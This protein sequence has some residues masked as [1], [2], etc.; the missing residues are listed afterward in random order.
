MD[1]LEKKK[2]PCPSNKK[3]K[4]PPHLQ[5]TYLNRKI[6]RNIYI[7]IVIFAWPA[8]LIR[9]DLQQRTVTAMTTILLNNSNLID[10][11]ESTPTI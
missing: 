6:H 2:K 1:N 11:L 9:L 7:L 10:L 5:L 3:K 8:Q 4:I